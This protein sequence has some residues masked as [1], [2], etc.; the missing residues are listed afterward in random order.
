MRGHYY[1]YIGA[2]LVGD[3]VR[4]PNWEH[5]HRLG[6]SGACLVVEN[7]TGAQAA[8]NARREDSAHHIIHEWVFLNY[9]LGVQMRVRE[10]PPSLM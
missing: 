7:M 3:T 4:F 1:N 10:H 2:F 6:F 9:L 8:P 5:N